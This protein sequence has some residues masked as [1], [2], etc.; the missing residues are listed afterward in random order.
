MFVRDEGRSRVSG[1]RSF[2][3][4]PRARHQQS[5]EISPRSSRYA[6]AEVIK[7]DV[8]MADFVRSAVCLGVNQCTLAS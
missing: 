8:D 4:P 3:W 7:D 1:L 6:A 2:D 5:V